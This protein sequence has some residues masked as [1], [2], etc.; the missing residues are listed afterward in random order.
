MLGFVTYM[1]PN[2]SLLGFVLYSL[3][4]DHSSATELNS[5]AMDKYH[6]SLLFLLTSSLHKPPFITAHFRSSLHIL[7]ITAPY[8]A[9][10]A[11]CVYNVQISTADF[12][13]SNKIV[14]LLNH[15]Y[16]SLIDIIN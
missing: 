4:I 5:L 15:N 8:R 1:K 2:P 9:S 6:I 13:S 14:G 16:F 7:C 10:P 11:N 12:C 3:C